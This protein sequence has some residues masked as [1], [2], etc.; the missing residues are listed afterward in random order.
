MDGNDI[1]PKPLRENLIFL[2]EDEI[3]QRLL[4]RFYLENEGFEVL[5]FFN[6]E[7]AL[8]ALMKHRPGLICLDLNLPK[9]SGLDMVSAV[10]AQNQSSAILML[11]ASEDPRNLETITDAGVDG[12]L[13]KPVESPELV[14]EVL[15]ILTHQ[16]RLASCLP[17]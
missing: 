7:D 6:G 16:E 8:E 5:D 2:V 10:R 4:Y 9:V 3:S 14:N 12:H 1:M 17:N 11:T 15:R 13:T